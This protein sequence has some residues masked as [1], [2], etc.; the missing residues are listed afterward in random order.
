[1]ESFV[2]AE[3]AAAFL[4][5]TRRRLLE[6]AR[7]GQ[8]PAHAVDES[9][10]RKTWRFRLSRAGRKH[11]PG[12]IESASRSNRTGGST[13]KEPLAG[14]WLEALLATATANCHRSVTPVIRG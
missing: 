8:V 13:K 7:K 9:A 14:N 4:C 3:E 5:I 1:M 2:T 11:Q 12:K 10:T 6:L